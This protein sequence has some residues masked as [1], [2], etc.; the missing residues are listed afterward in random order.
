MEQTNQINESVKQLKGML[1]FLNPSTSFIVNAAFAIVAF[2]LYI[3][4]G[5]GGYNLVS[6]LFEYAGGILGFLALV[7]IL[8]GVILYP[9]KKQRLC[10]GLNYFFAGFMLLSCL[11]FMFHWGIITILLVVLVLIPWMLFTFLKKDDEI[12]L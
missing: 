1:G 7:G 10:A 6:V 2:V 11:L 3:L 5:E 4:Q 12:K 9:M 8:A